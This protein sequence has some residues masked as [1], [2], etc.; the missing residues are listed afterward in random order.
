MAD[1]LLQAMKTDNKVKYS[2][3]NNSSKHWAADSTD[4][5]QETVEVRCNKD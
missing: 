5:V 4:T 2:Y 3:Q 1:G